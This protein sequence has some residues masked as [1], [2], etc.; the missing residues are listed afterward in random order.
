MGAYYENSLKAW[1]AK[2]WNE[3]RPLLA[4]Y[5]TLER[6]GHPDKLDQWR[7][8]ILSDRMIELVDAALKET[9]AD[10]AVFR[11]WLLFCAASAVWMA[12]GETVAP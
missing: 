3:R 5:A 9:K 12:I 1:S 10:A 7:L 11:C 6:I 2:L 8:L 4:R